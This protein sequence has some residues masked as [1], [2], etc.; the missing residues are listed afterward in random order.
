[1]PL[2]SYHSV[3]ILRLSP[4]KKHGATLLWRKETGTRP[5][6]RTGVIGNRNWRKVRTG[7]IIAHAAEKRCVFQGYNW[8][9]TTEEFDDIHSVLTPVP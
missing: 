9:G 4:K 1:M 8:P 3:T 5:E 7:V 6:V 2:N